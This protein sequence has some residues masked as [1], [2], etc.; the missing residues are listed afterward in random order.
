[1]AIA[2]TGPGPIDQISAFRA[3]ADHQNKKF[4]ATP[5]PA[6]QSIVYHPKKPRPMPPCPERA[7]AALSH[8]VVSVA[9]RFSSRAEAGSSVRQAS[10]RPA[11]GLKWRSRRQGTYVERSRPITSPGTP[12]H[13][14][15]VDPIGVDKDPGSQTSRIYIKTSNRT[16]SGPQNHI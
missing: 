3:V 4:L 1:M 10:F 2:T 16:T 15:R 6:A 5:Q 14:H 11:C 12:L 9:L 7:M 8:A 13:A